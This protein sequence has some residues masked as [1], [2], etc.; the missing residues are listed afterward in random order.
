MQ[1]DKIKHIIAGVGIALFGS[2][3]PMLTWY[4]SS[5]LLVIALGVGNELRDHYE[6]RGT[7]EVMDAIATITGGFAVITVGYVITL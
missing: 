6:K 3:L 4:E 7:P 2:A 5:A 1:Q